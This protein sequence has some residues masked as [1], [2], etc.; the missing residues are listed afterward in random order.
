M[1]RPLTTFGLRL[2]PTIK[3]ALSVYLALFFVSILPAHDLSHAHATSTDRV[4]IADCAAHPEPA[5]H[6]ADQCQICRMHG[7][8]GAIPLLATLPQ[9]QS[10]RTFVVDDSGIEPTSTFLSHFSP[11]SPPLVG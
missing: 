2:H 5:A 3:A 1:N 7:Q 6:N 10:P 8:L 9:E 4:S 11:R